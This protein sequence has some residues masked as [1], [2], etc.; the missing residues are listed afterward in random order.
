MSDKRANN[1]IWKL[2]VHDGQTPGDRLAEIID[3]YQELRKGQPSKYRSIEQLQ[4]RQEF[5]GVSLQLWIRKRRSYGLFPFVRPVLESDEDEAKLSFTTVDVCLFVCTEASLFATTSGAGYRIIENYVDYGFPFDMAKRLIANNFKAADV[6]E[7]AGP[8]TSRT[9]TY[10]QGYS[11][12]KSESFGKVWKKLIGRL[13]SSLL[14]EAS[15]LAKIIDPNKP[16]AL[17]V[18]SSF[19][20]RKSLNIG[21]LISLMKEMEELPEPSVEQDRELSFLDNLYPVKS[22]DLEKTLQRALVEDLR[23]AVADGKEMD[24]EICDPGSVTQYYAGSNFKISNWLIPG[25]P[26]DVNDL[27]SLIRSKL[28]KYCSDEDSFYKRFMSLHISYTTTDDDESTVV[29]SELHKFLHGQ[30]QVSNKSFFLLDKVWYKSQGE[31]LANLKRDFIEEVFNGKNPILMH[32]A[33]GFVDWSDVD[34]DGFNKRHAKDHGFYYGDKIFARSDRGKVELFDLLKPDPLNQR[35]Y[36]IHV[37][38]GFDANM[39]DACSQ[40][41]VAAEVIQSDI[42]NGKTLLSGYYSEWSSSPLNAVKHISLETF[43]SWFDLDEIVYVVLCSTSVDFASESFERERLSSHIA[44]REIIATR[45]EF[46]NNGRVF[47][48]AHTK[49]IRSR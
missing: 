30:V 9:E 41:T 18:K 5:E 43:L 6:R 24:L 38:D 12:S 10:R 32:K 42:E 19:V 31:F 8:R 33:I 13:N 22:A 21:Q 35:L 15:Y 28:G 26:P 36:V 34:E 20:L 45:N 44:R 1:A 29:R 16:P 14:P 27:V 17:E 39:R 3:T 7:F 47:R 40:I 48:L 37:K 11:I 4:T 2:V 23:L 25:D 49:R 46:K